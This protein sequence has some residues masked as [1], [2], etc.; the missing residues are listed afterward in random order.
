MLIL[1]FDLSLLCILIRMFQNF[2]MNF[3]ACYPLDSKPCKVTSCSVS[4]REKFRFKFPLL[5]VCLF[6]QLAPH[7][8]PQTG[9][10][11]AQGMGSARCRGSSPGKPLLF[12]GACPDQDPWGTAAEGSRRGHSSGLQPRCKELAMMLLLEKT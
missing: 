10:L 2:Y 7:I 4:R 8:L 1:G 5:L 11:P 12:W 3:P 9:L 6:V